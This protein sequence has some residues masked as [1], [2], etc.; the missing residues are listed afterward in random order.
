[1]AFAFF[2]VRLS[3]PY[4]ATEKTTALTME[5]FIIKV[6]SLLFNMLSKFVK[7]F[8]SRRK[9][10]LILWP[11]LPLAVIL[12]PKKIMLVTV[13]IVSPPSYHEVMRPDVMILVFWM[14]SF[15]PVFSLSSVNFI[16]RLFSPSLLSAIK[17]VSSAYLSLWIF[18]LETLIIASDSSILAFHMMY[19]ACKLNKQS[20]SIQPWHAPFPIWNQ[21]FV[22]VWF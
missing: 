7:T 9:Y 14:L 5:T 10:L 13:S 3:H 21:S 4:M 6:M 19:T 20:D 11:K 12:E 15:K 16:K 2:M 8:L 18:I 22:H 17:V 1:M